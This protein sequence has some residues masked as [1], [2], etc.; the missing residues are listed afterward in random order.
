MKNFHLI[1]LF[2]LKVERTRSQTNI[3]SRPEDFFPFPERKTSLR[4]KKEQ[5]AIL[6]EN[7]I[8]VK[9][10]KQRCRNVKIVKSR[11]YF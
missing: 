3:C 4:H 1:I 9:D 5:R 10:F 2:F 7:L 8:F 6:V 11:S